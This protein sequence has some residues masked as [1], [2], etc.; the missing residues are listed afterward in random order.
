M[1]STLA[2]DSPH[3]RE[4]KTVLDSGYHLVYS[5]FQTLAVEITFWIQN[6]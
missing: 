1:F 5:G 6:C 2:Y 4:P 3:V